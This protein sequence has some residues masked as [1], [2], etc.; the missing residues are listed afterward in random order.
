MF[1]DPGTYV[2]ADRLRALDAYRQQPAPGW[3]AA[4]HR[5]LYGPRPLKARALRRLAGA[6]WFSC[7]LALAVA[8][9]FRAIAAFKP[10]VLHAH[11]F[12]GY[13][14]GLVAR[15]ATGR[16]LVHTV[17]ALL[18]QMRDARGG[19]LP[20]LYR[21]THRAVSRYFT[22]MPSEQLVLG[23]PRRKLYEIPGAVDLEE[24]ATARARRSEDRESVRRGL[25]IP[26]AAPV[27]IV[28]GR[29]HRSKGHIH[30]IQALAQMRHTDAH[31]ILLGDGTE[32]SSLQDRARDLRL[33]ERTHF[34]G[35]R[36]DVLACYSASDVYL[37][38][39]LMEG[40]N[41]SSLL[42]MAAG[43]PIVGSAAGAETDLIP[44]VG[45]GV[46]VAPGDDVALARECDRLLADADLRDLLVRRGAAFAQEHLDV[47]ATVR[48]YHG[49]YR[50]LSSDKGG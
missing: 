28:V 18:K 49:F 26:H 14:V 20:W 38:V 15:R 10:T 25:G 17:P 44:T 43:L 35:Y 4:L 36:E 41:M 39:G 45:H 33:Q 19:W 22:S 48:D 11:G 34:A 27:L 23:I 30:A 2:Y 12:V 9:T 7:S 6:I 8:E 50:A 37:R 42:A 24:V 40:D 21:R 13:V 47:R 3:L 1:P 29:L 16:P 31:L 5:V 32:R 46:L